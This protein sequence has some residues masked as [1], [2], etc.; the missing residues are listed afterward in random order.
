[1]STKN[2]ATFSAPVQIWHAAQRH[3]Y[4]AALALAAAAMGYAAPA[5]A[6]DKPGEAWPAAV[7]ARYRL[8]YLG[9]TVGHLDMN[10]TTSAGQYSLSGS[11][12]ISALLGAVTW[13]GTANVTGTIENGAP[14]PAIYSHE[15]HNKKKSWATQI[16]YKDR[17][18]PLVTLTPPPGDPPPDLVPLTP[19]SK[20]G[21]LDSLSALMLLT[22]ADGRP[23]C[24]R[25]LPIFDGKQRY[26]L[27]FS[28]KRMTRLPL[29][30]AKD[31]SEVGIVCRVT[32]EPIAGHRANDD[33]KAYTVNRDTEVVL[34]RIP[35]TDM[36]IP[37]SVT[38]PTAWGTGSMTTEKIEVTTIAGT[39]I[40]LKE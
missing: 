9:I 16:N 3:L 26:D 15:L 4:G 32:Y 6:A 30:S 20:A 33:T 7:H 18:A 8:Q 5:N 27:V 28:F 31:T 11:G 17:G 38:I 36:L 37:Y 1:M 40:A 24:A 14:A 23:P 22:K 10:S 25:R 12:R 2:T 39:K 34:R 21:T 29:A 35:G 19:A 13:G